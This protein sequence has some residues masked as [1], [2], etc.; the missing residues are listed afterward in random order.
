M[1]RSKDS[2]WYM[3]TL[4]RGLQPFDTKHLQT[5]L[6]VDSVPKMGETTYILARLVSAE[7]THALVAL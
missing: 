3:A 6:P 2:L 1:Q 5:A 4:H 7:R